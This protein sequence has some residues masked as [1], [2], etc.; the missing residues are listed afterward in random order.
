MP[1]Q[2]RQIFFFDA[3]V[4][5]YE[6]LIGGL[7]AESAWFVLDADRDGIT[8]MQSIL[9]DYSGLDAIQIISHGAPATLYLG[10]TTVNQQT[11]EGYSQQLKAIGN[12]LTETGDL[13]IYGCNVAQGASGQ[14]FIEQLSA[15]TRADVAASDD[16]TGASWLGGD[17]ELETSNGIVESAS[18]DGDGYATA[19]ATVIGDDTSN[20]LTGTTGSDTFNGLGGN[21]TIDGRGGDDIIDGGAGTDTAFFP[22]NYANYTVNIHNGVARVYG[23][24]SST[25]SSNYEVFL[26][27]VE[28]L[29][30]KDSVVEEIPGTTNNLIIKTSN[31]E[32]IIGTDG[33]DII[34]GRGGSDIMDGGTGSDTAIFFDDQADFSI[35]TLSGITRLMGLSTASNRYYGD[36]MFL[37]NVEHLQ[38]NDATVDIPASTNNL[39]RSYSSVVNGTSSNDTIDNK[40]YD[41]AVIDGGVGT[42]TVIF[43][44]DRAD[45]SITTLSGITRL[46]G[47][48]TASNRYYND[49]MFLTNVEHLQ[50]NDATVDIPVSTNNLI[51]KTSS[52]ETIIGTGDDDIIDGRGGSDIMDGGTGTDTAIF[53]DDRADFSIETVGGLTRLVGLSTATSR[54]ADD[55][56]RLTNVEHLQ[57]KDDVV[58][59]VTGPTVSTYTMTNLGEDEQTTVFRADLSGLGLTQIGSLNITDDNSGVGGGPGT[60]SG[61]DVDFVF[62]DLDGNYETSGDRVFGSVFGFNTGSIRP[63][64]DP[65]YLPTE[66]RPGPT[67]GSFA[68][69]VIDYAIATL[70]TRDG[71]SAGVDSTGFLTLGDGG[72]LAVTFSSPVTLTGSEAL[73]LGELTRG[74]GEDV[75]VTFSENSTSPKTINGTIADGSDLFNVFVQRVDS[76]AGIDP[77]SARTWILIHGLADSA[78]SWTGHIDEQ[79]PI[80]VDEIRNFYGNDQILVIDWSTAADGGFI[81]RYPVDVEARIPTVAAW[82]NSQLGASGLGFSG[83]SIELIG[84]SF[85]AYVADEFAE[86]MG[87]VDTI[88]ALDPATNVSL[89]LIPDEYNSV[90]R[91]D[92]D[93]HSNWSWAFIDQTGDFNNPT[94]PQ[95]ADE[96]FVIDGYFSGLT[97]HTGVRKVFAN[98]LADTDGGNGTNKYFQLDQLLDYQA[99]PWVQNWYDQYGNFDVNGGFEGV[100][101]ADNN[102]IPE[103]FDFIP[104]SDTPGDNVPSGVLTLHL[105]GG[106]WT[107]HP[108]GSHSA[109]GVLTIGLK[110]GL[111][112]MIEVSG[113]SYVLGADSLTLSG[114][115]ASII[116]G[117]SRPL[118]T[119]QATL[120][121]SGAAGNIDWN[122]IEFEAAGLKPTFTA[123]NLA[124]GDVRLQY[125]AWGLPADLTVGPLSLNPDTLVI[126]SRGPQLGLSGSVSFPDLEFSLFNVVDIESTDWKV[127]YEA[128]DDQMVIQGGFN[129]EPGWPGLP[130]IAASLGA[131]GLIIQ[132]GEISDIAL[133]ISLSDFA[134]KGW[135]FK[136]V[137]F[138][139]D[140]GDNNF[141]GQGSLT[142]PFASG[143]GFASALGFTLTP[144]ELDSASL[145]VSLP[146]PGIPVFSTGWFIDSLGGGLSNLASTNPAPVLL[147]GEVGLDGPGGLV[148]MTLTGQLDINHATG[149]VSG[150]VINENLIQFGGAA[151]LDWNRDLVSLSSTANF[152]NGFI[153]GDFNFKSDFDLNFSSRGSAQVNILKQTL[154]GDY[155]LLFSNDNDLSNDYVAGWATSQFSLPLLGSRS[156]TIGIKYTFDGNW[157]SFGAEEVPLY[158]SWIVDGT[159][160]DLMVT[161]E[162]ENAATSPVHT[163]VIVYDDLA[164][165][166]VREIIQEADYAAHNIAI[167]EEWSSDYAKVVYIAAPTPGVWDVVV[168]NTDG[169]GEIAYAATT[170]LADTSLSVDTVNLQDNALTIDYNAINPNGTA[171]VYFFMDGDNV[172]FDG[173]LIGT[174]PE[175]DGASQIVLQLVGLAP[176]DYWIYA[177]QEDGLSVPISAYAATPV[178]LDAWWGSDGDNSLTGSDVADT[179]HGLAGDDTLTGGP[180]ADT[181][182]GGLGSDTLIGGPDKDS[183]W[184]DHP[185]DHV[186]ETSSL[187]D[188]IDS[189]YASLSWTLSANLENLTLL[190]SKKF[191]ASG[192]SLSNV[193]TGNEAANVLD[194]GVGTDTLNG[195]AGNDVYVVDS[196]NDS[197]QETQTSS[198]EIDSVRSFVDW[199]LGA[200]LENLTLLG[201]KNLN[202]SGNSLNNTLT[203]NGGNNTF[204]GGTGNDFLDGASGN[205]TLTGGADADTFAFTTPL[206]ALRN[207]DTVTDFSSGTDKIQLSPAI[208]RDL[209]FSGTPST[210][211][212]F[213]ADSAAQDADDRILYDQNNG[214]LSY[215]ADG[216]GELAA[217][218]FAVMN[219]APALLYTDFVVG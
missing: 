68:A 215:D 19:L 80:I 21:D 82:L 34:D 131:D 208:F 93:A 139:L 100:I 32:T 30:F 90:A 170:S 195:C 4:A 121:L 6:T 8:Q 63:T 138:S 181:L 189:V 10:D 78:A 7:P 160:S 76:D 165:T 43:F 203:G 42:D 207:I 205:D 151:T 211:A 71:L 198:T 126:S 18:L 74:T 56:I 153:T 31:G 104:K 150:H 182:I 17:W 197:I 66:N 77:S 124:N 108:N 193:L 176:G 133:D 141:S 127:S 5:D 161:V 59:V 101:W 167:V 87:G 192:N 174:T 194:G 172:G 49:E 175:S 45:F 103:A 117:V 201:T 13:L 116:D 219:S 135:G 140:T 171:D 89:P 1:S 41:S 168:V 9:A 184:V 58:D 164:K 157:D 186:I 137:G 120:S 62:L 187:A 169:L 73:F 24:T 212:F 200:N 11:L 96:S 158:A 83:A 48:T 14:A 88:V 156:A 47:L 180:G 147:T 218:Q 37:T 95:T 152:V 109:M 84:H 72:S 3:R 65:Y 55:E 130:S 36:E 113:G 39:I 206:N 16:L 122:T 204:S 38:F 69:N 40:G 67:E 196:A 54:Y 98:M 22:Y 155:S 91:V 216:T 129:L 51:I 199:T 119:G 106:E 183:Y 134:I 52:S 46:V 60:A 27:N 25:N 178:T 110:V 114:T 105:S 50:F 2:T 107:D 202:G 28:N 85:G 79:T 132:N 210:A 61:F 209:D 144:F 53:F 35:T 86:L 179:I 173:R 143:Y 70:D 146:D 190:G 118:F 185:G 111:A 145:N 163:Q 123:L 162:W 214:A 99:G 33:D 12:A 23:Q 188:E 213:H 57:F 159:I 26:T 177:L 217:V 20:Q 142:L 81:D 94:T 166:Q 15:I 191:S 128:L 97:G 29:Q 92:F 136:D 112:S 75:T 125:D 115:F 102:N 44:D 148:E 149:S 64:T 154:A